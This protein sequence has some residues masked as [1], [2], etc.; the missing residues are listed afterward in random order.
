[1]N[2]SELLW[3]ASQLVRSLRELTSP[4]ILFYDKEDRMYAH[5]VI[6]KSELSRERLIRL[7][8]QGYLNRREYNKH[9]I[10]EMK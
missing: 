6:N 9:I 1:M 10:Q 8:L 7:V 5:V 4:S 3:S 2:Q